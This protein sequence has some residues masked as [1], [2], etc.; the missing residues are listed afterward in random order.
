[1]FSSNDQ[2]YHHSAEPRRPGNVYPPQTQDL[3]HQI[4]EYQNQIERIQKKADSRKESLKVL[5]RMVSEKERSIEQLEA[6]LNESSTVMKI[7]AQE[8]VTMNEQY[9]EEMNQKVEASS[10]RVNYLQGLVD[11]LCSLL[12][13]TKQVRQRHYEVSVP[14]VAPAELHIQKITRVRVAANPTQVLYQEAAE[15][16]DD[17]LKELKEQISRIKSTLKQAELN[18]ET[19]KRKY[20]SQVT[21]V[22]RL[23]KENENL[24]FVSKHTK[25]EKED[26]ELKLHNINT[27]FEEIS[28]LHSNCTQNST[29]EYISKKSQNQINT[30]NV[31]FSLKETRSKEDELRAE[32]SNLRDSSFKQLLSLK[33]EAE[34]ASFRISNLISEITE[35]AN[36]LQIL[37][38]N[39][40]QANIQ[41]AD[42]SK[43]IHDMK[44]SHREVENTLRSTI[45]RLK[46]DL[47]ISRKEVIRL[48]TANSVLQ[49][50]VDQSDVS[51]KDVIRLKDI[52]IDRLKADMAA[53]KR[54]F[55]GKLT[56][57]GSRVSRLEAQL[58]EVSV[59]KQELSKKLTNIAN[60]SKE[61]DKKTIAALS[62]DLNQAREKLRMYENENKIL[63]SRLANAEIEVEA[64]KNKVETEQQLLKVLKATL[65]NKDL[66]IRDLKEKHIEAQ[67]ESNGLNLQVQRLTS[68]SKEDKSSISTL[69]KTVGQLTADLKASREKL[70]A[71][72]SKNEAQ[73]SKLKVDFEK[74]I[75]SQD[76]EL[77]T[78]RATVARLDPENSKLKADVRKMSSDIE[79][80]RDQASKSIKQTEGVIEDNYGDLIA[81]KNAEFDSKIA[82]LESDASS[83]IVQ[84][85][86]DHRLEI[87]TLTEKLNEEKERVKAVEEMLDAERLEWG[88]EKERYQEAI[89]KAEDNNANSGGRLKVI[90]ELNEE[91]REIV[92]HFMAEAME[93]VQI[94]EDDLN[95]EETHEDGTDKSPWLI[96]SEEILRRIH[97]ITTAFME[98][99]EAVQKA[100]EEIE[101]VNKEKVD[102]ESLL[103]EAQTK[104][105]DLERKASNLEEDLKLT[106]SEIMDLKATLKSTEDTLKGSLSPQDRSKAQSEI[107]EAENRRLTDHLSVINNRLISLQKDLAMS[108]SKLELER[109]EKNDTEKKM[110]EEIKRLELNIENLK[111][112]LSDA[113]REIGELIKSR[114]ATRAELEDLKEKAQQREEENHN[115]LE[116]NQL[117][118]IRLATS[119]AKLKDEMISAEQ[120]KERAERKQKEAEDKLTKLKEQKEREEGK[121]IENLEA[122]LKEINRLNGENEKLVIKL[123]ETKSAHKKEIQALN[124]AQEKKQDIAPIN[125]KSDIKSNHT[126]QMEEIRETEEND[127]SEGRHPMTSGR[128]AKK[129]ES[130]KSTIKELRTRLESMETIFKKPNKNTEREELDPQNMTEEEKNTKLTEL[131]ERNLELEEYAQNAVDHV[132]QMQAECQKV[133]DRE[134]IQKEAEIRRLTDTLDELEIKYAREIGEKSRTISKMKDELEDKLAAKDR[135]IFY[136]K[137]E[138]ESSSVARED[139]INNLRRIATET[140]KDRFESQPNHEHSFHADDGTRPKSSQHI[141]RKAS[142][143]KELEVEQWKEKYSKL[144]A[145]VEDLRKR[146]ETSLQLDN[147]THFT[148]DVHITA[149]NKTPPSI[150]PRAI[151]AEDDNENIKQEID[152][153]RRANGELR[154][155]LERE[156]EV[157]KQILNDHEY[158]RTDSDYRITNEDFEAIKHEKIRQ[159]TY[160]DDNNLYL[161]LMAMFD[162]KSDGQK[163]ITREN[164]VQQIGKFIDELKYNG[165]N[166]DVA[167]KCEEL[168][169]DNQQLK[170]QVE[171]L[172]TQNDH[173]KDILRKN[174]KEGGVAAT[175]LSQLQPPEHS[176]S[177]ELESQ[178]LDSINKFLKEMDL[179]AMDKLSISKMNS[180]FNS[181]LRLK[182][183]LMVELAAKEELIEDLR[184]NSLKLS[185]D[186]GEGQG[187]QGNN[188]QTDEF[189]RQKELLTKYHNLRR[190]HEN[191]LAEIEQLRIDKDSLSFEAEDLRKSSELEIKRRE[192]LEIQINILKEEAINTSEDMKAHTKKLFGELFKSLNENKDQHQASQLLE[193]L[194]S[195]I[196][197]TP[198]ERKD[199]MDNLKKNKFFEKVM[200]KK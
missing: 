174:A 137:K 49:A 98:H 156:L 43:E 110:T 90:L 17:E 89:Q 147:M 47:D 128:L 130:L 172:N 79:V 113:E 60:E 125:T 180:V 179:S 181:I 23:A 186:R 64:V 142:D 75:R 114:D 192:A 119:I 57:S 69:N 124:E 120:A 66:E 175:L 139:E 45:E 115:N 86:D 82:A 189:H 61:S 31:G 170:K 155:E 152:Y 135:E 9:T 101:L 5:Y 127:D 59:E 77:A 29:S 55:D 166:I 149:P 97:D 160:S 154:K 84:L 80:C 37:S 188:S 104:I 133:I 112:D 141:S 8:A 118:T 68:Q 140:S 15:T 28:A 105:Q 1:M 85:I 33:T 157:R 116:V 177:S 121:F 151:P 42:Q 62:G 183:R 74:K 4:W 131:L 132:S 13:S 158:V 146:R 51:L 7:I 24:K 6:A 169:L 25:V 3:N 50:N 91:D 96:A 138:H 19:F 93:L 44:S 18:G 32:L 111:D 100:N 67:Q 148:S 38:S 143:R 144:L 194:T 48:T 11:R 109:Q 197:Y 200:K 178:V 184:M 56:E 196:G 34:Q 102:A 129:I 117:E 198:A 187:T 58:A 145:E 163:T 150:K 35:K 63:S 168:N 193:Y 173:L 12:R 92:K 41:L 26:L 99:T 191:T 27:R 16:T 20:E 199:L 36:E 159:G 14:E 65:T 171:S 88:Q 95:M 185:S 83:R 73:I 78:I 94:S 136:V 40:K 46:H 182:R 76:D 164:I 153:L 39:L 122:K 53:S 108:N 2:W 126:P 22:E 176:I 71:Q 103:S 167:E 107:V 162:S 30:Q 81:A 21:T 106:Q 195:M 134:I 10:S 52:E 165:K 70:T 190:K 161:D 87:Q 123:K 72:E 54:A